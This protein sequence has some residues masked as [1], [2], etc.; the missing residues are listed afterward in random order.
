[1]VPTKKVDKTPHE[2]CGRTIE[3]EEIQDEVTSPSENSSKIPME[4]KGF[5]PPQ[6]EVFLICRSA[7]THQ[8][9]NRLCLNVEVEEHSLRDLNEPANYKAAIL[10][11]ES[12][13]RCYKCER[14]DY[15]EKFSSV[16]DIRAIRI[17]I[18]I[19]A[20][21]DCDIWQMNVKYAFLNG[22]LDED[23]Y[24]VQP[25][26]FV[27]PKHLRKASGS[28]VTFIILYVDDIIM[29]GN[30]I[31]SL[32]S[33][34]TYL[35][36]CFAMKD[37][38]EVSFILGIRLYRDRLQQLIRL[39]QSAYM[40]KILKRYRMDTSKLGRI[41]GG[42]G[43]S[44]RREHLGGQ[45]DGTYRRLTKV[46]FPKFDAEDVLG[47]LY[48]VNKFFE[49]DQI[50]DD[51]QRLKLIYMHVFGKALNWHKQFM[52]KFSE[53]VTWG[54]YET[55]IKK[56]FESVFE[57]PMVELKNLKQTA[58]VQTIRIRGYVGKH[59]LHILVDSGSTHNFLDL[60]VVKKMGCNIR[61]MCPL[62]VSVAN[63]QAM[64]TMYECKD[65]QWELQRKIYVADVIILPLGGC[66][67]VL[68]IQWLSTLGVIQCDLKILVMEFMKDGKK[69]VLRGKFVL[70]FFDDILIYSQSE[71]EHLGHLK[72][73][74][75]VMKEHPLFAK[76][77][78]CHFEVN[79]VE[80]L[81][82]FITTEGVIIDPT[83]IE[84]MVNWPIPQIVKHLRGFLGLTGY[85][86]RF[87]RHYAK[88]SKPLT[89]LIKKNAF[90][91]DETAQIAF[92]KLKQAMTQAPVLDLPNFQKVFTVETYA[93]GVGIAMEKWRGYLMD[94]HFKI[95]TD[96]FSLK[97]LLDQRLITPFQSKWFPKL[98]GFDYEISYKKGSENIVADALSRVEGSD[99]VLRTIIIKHFHADAIGGHSETNVTG[100]KIGTLFYWK[101]MHKGVKKFIREYDVCQIQKP[102][103][104]AYLGLLQ[105]LPI[106]ERVWSEISTGFIV[107]LP[108]SQGKSVIFVVVDRLSKY[109][110]FMALIHLYTA[111]FVAQVFLDNLCKLHGLPSS[112]VSDRDAIFLSNFWQSLFKLLKVELKMS[113][114]YH[115]QTDG[116]TEVV[117]KCLECNLRCMTGERPKEWVVDKTLQARESTIEMLKLHLK[118]SQD[119]MKVSADRKRPSGQGICWEVMED[120]GGSSGSGEEGRKH[121]RNGCREM[122]GNIDKQ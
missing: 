121:G 81:G 20:F 48:R 38:E 82:H 106:L 72:K 103:L 24:I 105:S 69:Y 114:T 110:R 119:N 11:L 111:S 66:E 10:D 19:A 99:E 51:E 91:W 29:M 7:R 40:N 21:N 96:H 100:H 64:S 77:S 60:S 63:G 46:E 85:Y 25:E 101:D 44:Q 3:L 5:E 71:K 58:N 39:S 42:E 102:D 23:V 120:R 47:W 84:A 2:L 31:P 28:D 34:K 18:A 108:K 61:K 87:I 112:I 75:Q 94:R 54:V 67:M 122:A 88:I 37:L 9:P 83:K 74:L 93:L 73:V 117:N 59:L 98:L 35:G 45:N 27:D 17:L 32:Q 92:T 41:N 52:G 43:T 118:R 104:C 14:V 33:V 22:Y 76:M 65:F 50:G 115:P 107:G 15:E 113:T 86:R 97:Y 36:N 26:G 56:R 116:Q 53:V 80:Y 4:V 90:E 70:V 49:M 79:K 57:D 6:E 78:K 89:R 62:Q 109:S 8:A 13:A 55:H 12:D 95:K 16:I 68:G 1:M 30:H